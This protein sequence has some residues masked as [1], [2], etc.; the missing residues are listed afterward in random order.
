MRALVR[1]GGALTILVLAAALSGLT[2][3]DAPPSANPAPDGREASERNA[4][5]THDIEDDLSGYYR[6]VSAVTA[7]NYRLTHLF[8]GQTADF[9]TWEG[10]A[11]SRAHGPVM[12]EFANAAG[13]TVRVMPKAYAVGDGRVRF[14][15]SHPDLGEV[16]FVGSL[17]AGALATAKRN[18]GEEAPVLSGVLRIGGRS[19]GEQKFRWYG[20]D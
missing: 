12:F 3:C 7:G 15:G 13:A 11:K 2:G 14:A 9:E 17:D 6:P 1:R 5:F 8:L 20:G 4:V 18:L 10:G 16:S 19:F